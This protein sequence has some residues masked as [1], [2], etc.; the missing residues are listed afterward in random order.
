MTALAADTAKLIDKWTRYSFP[1]AAG[2]YYKNAWIVGDPATHNVKNVVA[3]TATFISLGL[4]HVFGGVAAGTVLAGGAALEVDFIKEKTF[5]WLKNDGTI[6]KA[7][8]LFS[9][10]Y[11][12]DNAT[13]TA[14]A[15]TNTI[16]GTIY[17]VDAV[18]GVMIEKV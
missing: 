16:A 1:A 10:A 18:R 9:L 5:F 3:A 15:G 12:L 13:A 8:Q 6:T 11:F 4:C 7:A 2:T 14:T 17:D